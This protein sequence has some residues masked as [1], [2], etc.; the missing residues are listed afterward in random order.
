MDVSEIC[1][2]D[3]YESEFKMRRK[4]KKPEYRKPAIRMRRGSSLVQAFSACTKSRSEAEPEA[5]WPEGIA[6]N[7]IKKV[8]NRRGLI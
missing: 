6:Q 7:Q 2:I 3:I 5:A 1:N 4:R 8:K